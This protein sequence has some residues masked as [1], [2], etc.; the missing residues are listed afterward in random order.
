[1]FDAKK[2]ID[3]IKGGLLDS[4]QTWQSYLEEDHDW[5]D[6]ATLL[7]GPLI[8]ASVLLS[9]LFGW[10]FSSHY[11]LPQG[12]GFWAFILGLIAAT[13]GITVASFV[14]SYLAGVFKGKHDFN[15]GFAAVSLSAIPAYVGGVL[16]TLPLIGWLIALVLGIISLVY[17]YRIIPSYLQVP[18]GNRAIHYGVSLVSTIVIIFIINSIGHIYLCQ[19]IICIGQISYTP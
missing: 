1:M 12:G 11:M 2:T 17:L 6:T 16:G 7:T 4:S 15:K 13:I 8:L 3:L 5:K 19:Y 9:S 10:V 18:D 14:F